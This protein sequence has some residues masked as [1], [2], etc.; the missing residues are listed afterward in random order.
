MNIANE[1]SPE[2]LTCDGELSKKRI[3][4]KIKELHLR[5]RQL[6]EKAGRKVS[7]SD[8]YKNNP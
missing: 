3:A 4:T 7:E 8:I 5:W 6:E 1:L 2:N